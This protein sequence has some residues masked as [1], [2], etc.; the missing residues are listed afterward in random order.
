[1]NTKVFV[2]VTLIIPIMQGKTLI[3]PNMRNSHKAEHEITTV[4]SSTTKFPVHLNGSGTANNTNN[5]NITGDIVVIQ[6]LIINN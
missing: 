5:V 2:I 6:N 1:M 4:G 3:N